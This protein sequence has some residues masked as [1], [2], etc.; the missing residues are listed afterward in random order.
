ME[1]I[2]Q[3]K[4][5]GNPRM[6]VDLSKT[7]IQ[8]FQQMTKDLNF[9]IVRYRDKPKVTYNYL[10][11]ID[12]DTC[13]IVKRIN[14]YEDIKD[15]LINENVYLVESETIYTD[16]DDVKIILKEDLLI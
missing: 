5:F 1:V 12:V 13:K 8:E 15:F 2:I 6:I 3:T 4:Y 7:T 10:Y 14:H 16:T 9:K 11:I